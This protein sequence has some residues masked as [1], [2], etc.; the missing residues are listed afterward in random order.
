MK[1]KDRRRRGNGRS[2]RCWRRSS[3][4]RKRWRRRRRRRRRLR[5]GPPAYQLM[6]QYVGGHGIHSS[7]RY[8]QWAQRLV[9]DQLKFSLYQKLVL[10]VRWWPADIGGLWIHKYTV[11]EWVQRQSNFGN[12]TPTSKMKL[13]NVTWTRDVVCRIVETWQIL[14]LFKQ[15]VLKSKL[16]YHLSFSAHLRKSQRIAALTCNLIMQ[17]G[18]W[19][20]QNT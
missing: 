5:T 8:T 3:R 15:I 10:I 4:R 12:L 19:S 2:R 13:A 7:L 17:K 18:C 14:H 6:G 1:D 20:K 9:S 11:S 16:V